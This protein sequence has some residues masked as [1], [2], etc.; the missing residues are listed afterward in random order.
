MSQPPEPAIESSAADTSGAAFDPRHLLV[1]SIAGGV[2]IHWMV[3]L[4][5]LPESWLRVAPG[6][7]L[8]MAAF[9]MMTWASRTMAAHDTAVPVDEPSTVIVDDGPFGI[10]RN[11]IYVG[12]LI[13]QL[14]VAVWANSAWLLLIL[15]ASFIALNLGVVAREEAYLERLFGQDYLDYKGRVRRWL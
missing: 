12:L 15:L 13:L 11:P 8:V 4:H 1:L 6:V 3:P 7:A 10:S 14:G 2:L 9:G 5:W